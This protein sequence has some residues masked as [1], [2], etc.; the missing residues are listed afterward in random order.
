MNNSY[1]VTSLMGADLNSILKC[2][3][4]TDEH[5]QFLV[6]QILR[7]LK[8]GTDY[9]CILKCWLWQSKLQWSKGLPS[10]DCT[11]CFSHRHHGWRYCLLALTENTLQQNNS[12][13][14]NGSQ[15]PANRLTKACSL[16]LQHTSLIFDIHVMLNWHLSKTL[17]A[18]QYH[19]TILQAQVYLLLNTVLVFDLMAGSSQLTYCVQYL[20]L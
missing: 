12:S 10:S 7:G 14:Q 16:G 1:M 13:M 5:V 15:T 6:Y 4:L 2:Q 11:D 18:D 9:I 8:V 17:A 20:C 3:K 19:M